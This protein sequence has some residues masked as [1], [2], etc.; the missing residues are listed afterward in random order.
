MSGYEPAHVYDVDSESPS[1]RSTVY[2][3]YSLFSRAEWLL[4]VA[5][6]LLSLGLL[7]VIAYIFW[8]TDDKPLS[9]WQFPISLNAVISILTTSCSAAMM[10]GVSE[11]ISQ[12][13]WLHFKKGPRQLANLEKFDEASRGPW[14]SFKFL[15]GITWNLATLGAFITICRLAF[16]PLAQQVVEYPERNI[17]RTDGSATFGYAHEYDR[18]LSGAM[19]N[20]KMSAV[21]HDPMMQSAILQGIYDINIP[22]IFNCPGACKWDESYVSLGF[23]STCK[24]V[25]VAT[26]RTEDCPRIGETEYHRGCNM[27][28]PGGIRLSTQHYETDLQT[29]FRLNASSTMDETATKIPPGFPDLVTFAVYR[30]TSDGNFTPRNINITECALSL[31]AYEYSKGHANGS[32]FK[33]DNIKEINLPHKRWNI[34][35]GTGGFNGS[36]WTNASKA[37]GLPK[38]TLGWVDIKALQFFFQSDMISAEWV[39]GNYDNK[40]PGISAALIGDVDLE[41]RFEKMASSMTDYLRA[42]PNRKIAKGQRVDRVTFV[43]IRWVWLIGPVA[44]ELAALVFAL[45]TIARNRQT[46]QVPLWKSSALAVL[47]CQHEKGVGNGAGLIRSQVKD[48]KEIEKI[49]EEAKVQLE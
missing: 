7:F 21:P 27:T 2:K 49:A 8:I 31:T 26:L 33:F 41:K 34:Y 12:L 9:D 35:G 44:I 22:Q 38:L 6:L 10:H 5:T 4:E 13:K 46:R 45:V 25:T 14:G 47:A 29:T 30:A 16:A 36:I 15:Y 40:N 32:D 24:N 18:K 19:F 43:S 39:D 1:T 48:I 28:T 20:H 23:K 3:R 11:F 37:D 17:N 42:G